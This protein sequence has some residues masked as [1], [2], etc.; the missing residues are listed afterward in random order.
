MRSTAAPLEGAAVFFD[1]SALFD[2]IRRE[3][4]PGARLLVAHG[5]LPPSGL[6]EAASYGVVKVSVQPHGGSPP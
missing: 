4:R 6:D 2:K 5:L 3:L 1:A